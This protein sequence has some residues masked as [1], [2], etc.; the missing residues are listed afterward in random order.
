[1]YIYIYICLLGADELF[2]GDRPALLAR[3]LSLG[4]ECCTP[5]ILLYC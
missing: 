1:M 3:L 5:E 2:L 4:A